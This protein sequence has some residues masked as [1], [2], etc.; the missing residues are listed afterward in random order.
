M[1]LRLRILKPE[2]MKPG[3]PYLCA[4]VNRANGAEGLPA[5]LEEVHNFDADVVSEIPIVGL[6]E[7][8]NA[9]R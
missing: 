1:S 4:Q 5:V 6:P 8:R 9:P 3:V 7:A 2:E